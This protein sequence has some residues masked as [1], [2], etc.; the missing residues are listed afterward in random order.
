MTAQSR[1]RAEHGRQF[2][3][4]PL[5]G[6]GDTQSRIHPLEQREAEIV[7]EVAQPMTDGALREAEFVRGKCHAAMA[8]YGIEGDEGGERR[9]ASER[10]GHDCMKPIH[11]ARRNLHLLICRAATLVRP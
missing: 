6:V 1:E 9:Q 7:F 3:R 11:G 8:E 10:L 4:Q 2:T 5:A